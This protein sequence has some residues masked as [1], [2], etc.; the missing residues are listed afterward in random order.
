MLRR[1]TARLLIVVAMVASALVSGGAGAQP[2][3]AFDCGSGYINRQQD[4]WYSPNSST[5]WHAWLGVCDSYWDPLYYY[6]GEDSNYNGGGGAP[7]DY[8]YLHLRAWRCG[9]LFY[10]QTASNSYA[11]IITLQTPRS[12]DCTP[13]ADGQGNERLSATSWWWYLNY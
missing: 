6:A 4:N 11:S 1:Y 7:V 2:A 5:T 10:D 9:T 12:G 3:L 8:M 13:Q